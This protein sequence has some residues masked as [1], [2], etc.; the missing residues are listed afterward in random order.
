MP[1]KNTSVERACATRELILATIEPLFAERGLFTISNRQVA[2]ADGQGSTAAV[3]YHVGTKTDLV[4]A[5][6]R[7]HAGRIEH[8][9]VPMLAEVGD[10]TDLRDWVGTR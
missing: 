8:L 7:K 2:A 6:A 5:I 4:P 9:R 1:L 10:S 3:G